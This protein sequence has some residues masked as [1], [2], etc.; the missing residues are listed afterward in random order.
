MSRPA[1]SPPPNTISDT[2]IDNNELYQYFIGI[3]MLSLATV[4]T[5][6]LG[7]LQERTYAQYGSAT[8]REGMFYTF[9]P[10]TP[11][12]VLIADLLHIYG[13]HPKGVT[14]LGYDTS[15]P[16]LYLVLALNIASQS[17]CVSG[18]SLLNSNVSAVSTNLVL[19][20]RKA[21][22]LCISVWYFGQ[23]MNLGL[24]IGACMVLLGTLLY[25]YATSAVKRQS[26]PKTRRLES[27]ASLI[28]A[29]GIIRSPNAVTN[30]SAKVHIEI[31]AKS[32]KYVNGNGIEPGS[33]NPGELNLRQR[34]AVVGGSN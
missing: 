24:G 3:A 8:W 21:L 31:L 18:A 20:A 28:K 30:G 1:P 7:I 34:K 32:P 13:G 12:F 15:V 16:L 2:R 9:A 33:G 26:Q 5:S 29:N 19:T 25:S 22:S 17:V 4:L 6:T 27:S 23:G 14:D 10:P 11:A